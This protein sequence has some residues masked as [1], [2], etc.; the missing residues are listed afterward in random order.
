MRQNRGEGYICR[1]EKDVLRWVQRTAGGKNT[2]SISFTRYTYS[3]TE[4]DLG[5][6]LI[7]DPAWKEDKTLTAA[8]DQ[9]AEATKS[10]IKK[11]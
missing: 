8:K 3:F 5:L 2:P 1:I 4:R 9:T 11:Y 10:L 6:R 7:D